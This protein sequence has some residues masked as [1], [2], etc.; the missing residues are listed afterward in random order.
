MVGSANWTMMVGNNTNGIAYLDN[1]DTLFVGTGNT[2]VAMNAATGAQEWT[3]ACKYDSPVVVGLLSPSGN[4]LYA[5]C[6]SAIMIISTQGPNSPTYV[7]TGGLVNNP[8]VL[9]YPMLYYVVQSIPAPPETD[10]NYALQAANV[11]SWPT[12]KWTFQVP[13]GDTLYGPPVLAVSNTQVVV[14]GDTSYWI[15]A[16]CGRNALAAGGG[17]NN[18]ATSVFNLMT[19]SSS[20]VGDSSGDTACFSGEDDMC[21]S[22]YTSG[23]GGAA[24][25]VNNQCFPGYALAGA[26]GRGVSTPNDYAFVGTASGHVVQSFY[27][28]D[29]AG[30]E[31]ATSPWQT[32][33]GQ[34]FSAPGVMSP[35]GSEVYMGSMSGSVVSLDATSGAYQWT[36]PVTGSIEYAGV[37]NYAATLLFE[38]TSKGEVVAINLAGTMPTPPDDMT[39]I[40]VAAGAVGGA[41]VLAVIGTAVWCIRGGAAR[42]R[43]RRKAVAVSRNRAHSPSVSSLSA[44][45]SVSSVSVPIESGR[46]EQAATYGTHQPLT[47]QPLIR[48]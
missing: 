48:L 25:T 44:A 22:T 8:G 39:V 3:V 24:G 35:D 23:T 12:V 41:L 13:D 14:A 45:S 9:N 6:E 11:G 30:T 2:V 46:R 37:L 1:T 10:V 42:L 17:V 43:A 21:C 5:S 47:R 33:V 19:T 27:Q 4:E 15:T 29:V 28:P 7:E 20:G 38:A 40:L 16:C 32:W 36:L 26:V 18:G 34:P 31:A